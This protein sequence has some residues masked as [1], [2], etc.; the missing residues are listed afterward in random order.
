MSVLYEKTCYNL[1]ERAK[2]HKSG[3]FCIDAFD[4]YSMCVVENI[5]TLTKIINKSRADAFCLMAIAT[6]AREVLLEQ[7]RG[8]KNSVKEL[9]F[10]L[11]E[12]DVA[13][14]LNIHIEKNDWMFELEKGE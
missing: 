14:D 10:Q 2:E 13:K 8:S 6:L 5:D 9:V 4:L 7:A 11:I 3:M 1:T 12:S